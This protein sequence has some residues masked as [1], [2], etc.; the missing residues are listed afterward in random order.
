MLENRKT[1]CVLP[2]DRYH[3]LRSSYLCETDPTDPRA[4]PLFAEFT[5]ASPVQIQVA[6]REILYD[7]NIKM[8]AKLR[9]DGVDVDLHEFDHGFHVFQLLAGKLPAADVALDM[10]TDFITTHLHR[11]FTN[12][13]ITITTNTTSD[14]LTSY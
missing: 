3:D 6:K 13:N 8:A 9:N 12:T 4:S 11:H 1:D 10:A 7:D 2:S 5:G 14:S